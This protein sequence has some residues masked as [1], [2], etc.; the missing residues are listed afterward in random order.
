M[1][2]PRHAF[3]RIIQQASL[4]TRSAANPRR[5]PEFLAQATRPITTSSTQ[6]WRAHRLP[7]TFP[8]TAQ[9]FASTSQPPPQALP[10]RPAPHRNPDEP[11]YELTFTCKACRH[12]SAHTVSKQGYHKGTTLITCPGCKARHLISDHLHVGAND[13]KQQDSSTDHARL[14]ILRYKDHTRGDISEERGV[15]AERKH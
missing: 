12:R 13:Q 6:P 11:C 3:K 10:H 7:I 15:S 14:D 2:I 1:S 5:G 9:R 4:A 8:T